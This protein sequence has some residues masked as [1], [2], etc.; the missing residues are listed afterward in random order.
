[1]I[2]KLTALAAIA[3][4]TT[5]CSRERIVQ[6]GWDRP[7]VVPDRYRVFI[8]DRLVR[9]IP[10]PLLDAA[11]HCLTVSVSVR[12]GPHTIRIVAYNVRGGISPPATLTVQ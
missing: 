1:M 10:P 8:D 2:S 6:L 3:A 5:G 12:P 7:V 9:E 11:C 4:M